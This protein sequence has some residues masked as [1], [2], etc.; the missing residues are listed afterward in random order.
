MK[1]VPHDGILWEYECPAHTAEELNAVSVQRHR[2][3]VAVG[4]YKYLSMKVLDNVVSKKIE[5]HHK[6][7]QECLAAEA[8][9]KL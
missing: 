7:Y 2:L 3:V 4:D 6:R 8:R 5:D 1:L 9:S